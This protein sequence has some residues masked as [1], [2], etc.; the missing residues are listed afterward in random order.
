M[1]MGFGVACWYEVDWPSAATSSHVI[2]S[3]MRIFTS[4]LA[5]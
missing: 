3:R 5:F 1:E 4:R 2:I